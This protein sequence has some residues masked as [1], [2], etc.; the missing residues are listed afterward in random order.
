MDFLEA[1]NYLEKVRSQKG[2]VL[3]LDTMRHLMAK[4]NNPQDKVKFIQVAGTN[5]KG[6]TAAYLTSILSEAGIKVG[7]YTSPAVFSSTEQYFACG[8]CISESE[9]AKGVTAVAEAAAS[10]DGETPTAFEQETALAFWYFAQKGCELAILEAGLGGDMDAT[11]IVT[12]TVC[13]IITS[14]SMDHCRILG[15]KI[16]EIAAHKAGII[17]PGA[18]VICIEQKEDAMEPIRAA[19]KAADTPLYEVHRDEVR[20][21]FS[22]KRESIVFFREF[23][24]LHLKMLG[25]CQPENAA[26]AVQAASVLSRSYPIEKKHIYDGIEKTRWG[27]RFEL[28]SGSPDIILDGAHNPDGIRRL[29]ESVNQMFGAVP[30]CYVCGVLADKDYEKEIEIL[31]G[32]ASN[33]FTVTPPSPRAMK[34]TDLKAAIKKRFSQLKVTSFD[35]EDGIE[36]AMEAAVSQNNPVV[37]CG[38]LTILARVKEWMKRNDR[39]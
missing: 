9:Y 34:S 13:S 37:V 7:R 20:Q 11:N 3:G 35:S 25:S 16:S 31:F 24:N 21:I 17:K 36:K 38:T 5:G 1:Q 27:G 28:H 18:P 23:E 14:I 39:M 4:L 30:I 15:N 29:R 33:V 26:L 8:S 32:R 22:D 6:S 19:A 12:T 10:L 2:I